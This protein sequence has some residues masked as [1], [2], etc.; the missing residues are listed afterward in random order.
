MGYISI[1]DSMLDICML[2]LELNNMLPSD[3]R[4]RRLAQ[5]HHAK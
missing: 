3:A 1:M 5:F 2:M 4:E